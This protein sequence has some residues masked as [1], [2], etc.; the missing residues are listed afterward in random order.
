MATGFV[1]HELYLWHDTGHYASVF[2][3]G[4]TIEPDLHAENP[5]TKRRLRNLLDVSGLSEHL[6]PVKPR[7]ASEEEIARFIAATT[8]PASVRSRPSAA[9]MPAFSRPSAPAASRSPA[10]R[11]AG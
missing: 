5:S 7:A 6:V 4:L 10:F 2:P 8:S 3:A 1:F 11:R 9:G